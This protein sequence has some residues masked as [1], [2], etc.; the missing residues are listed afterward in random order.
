MRGVF[1][2]QAGEAIQPTRYP[3]SFNLLAILNTLILS[4][5]KTI[6]IIGYPLTPHTSNFSSC[7]IYGPH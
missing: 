3:F 1:N 6:G 4:N 2:E 5:L 7:L